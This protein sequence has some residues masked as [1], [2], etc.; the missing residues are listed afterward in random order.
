MTDDLLKRASQLDADATPGPW[1]VGDGFGC[2]V[3][4]AHDRRIN[5]DEPIAI[6]LIVAD[7]ALIVLYRNELPAILAALES[8]RALLRR[9]VAVFD[10]V[11]SIMDLQEAL[12]PLIDEAR[13]RVGQ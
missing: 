8:D 5:G 3:V 12:D 6:D 4:Y 11:H 7:A 10:G 9:I 1:E 2:A 13:A